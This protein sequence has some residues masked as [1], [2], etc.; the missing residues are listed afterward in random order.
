[1][2]INIFRILMPLLAISI[3][4]LIDW[5]VYKGLKSAFK[6]DRS[7]RFKTIKFIFW[8]INIICI[9]SIIYFN[10]VPHVDHSLKT[11]L[12]GGIFV[13]YLTK[14]FFMLFLL[15]DDIRR[16]FNWIYI[17]FIKQDITSDTIQNQEVLETKQEEKN[18]KISRQQFLVKTGLIASAA[19]FI[20]FSKGII[21]NTHNY[22][23]HKQIIKLKNLPSAFK[24]LRIVQVSDIHSGSFIDSDGVAKGV[25]MVKDLKPDLIFFTGDLVN[26]ETAEVYEWMDIL[27]G[28]QAP[29]GVMSIYGNHDYGDYKQWGSKKE[30]EENLEALVKVHKDLGWHLMRNEHVTIDLH[31]QRIGLVGVENW[32]DQKRFQR[33]GDLQVATKNMPDVPVKL[34]L[35]H[36][37]SHWDKKVR[38]E[39]PDIDV[40]FAGHTH[41]FQFGIETPYFKFSPSQ[42][43]YKQWAGL[44][45]EGNQ[46]IYV[47]RG[48]GFL[49][50]P[51]RVGI[52]PEITLIELA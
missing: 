2:N 6:S 1:M 22:K 14:F 23:I 38:I 25:Q 15:V 5:Y 35:S 11:L 49:G 28:I 51:G 47:N 8:Q 31:G 34:L 48:F 42:W 40:M 13:V 37:P 19:P 10:L 46:H 50:Y 3:L 36:D 43:M 4:L 41:G 18:D 44:Y 9:A 45:S 20:L 52:M 39:T 32:G 17:R 30:K 29:M 27:S 33:F 21:T 7:K 26:N 24:G 12:G 16:F